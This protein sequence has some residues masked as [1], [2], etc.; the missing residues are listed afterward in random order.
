[1]VFYER[2]IYYEWS[3]M[4]TYQLTGKGS[5]KW[6][7]VPYLVLLVPLKA[8]FVAFIKVPQFPSET[9]DSQHWWRWILLRNSFIFCYFIESCNNDWKLL[10]PLGFDPLLTFSSVSNIQGNQPQRSFLIIYASFFI[11]PVY[12]FSL[13][14]LE[15]SLK[16]VEAQNQY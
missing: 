8:F 10:D 1:M 11:V 12:L 15:L 2:A 16:M 7:C 4:C 5:I 3:A 6:I 9:W 14:W 13:E